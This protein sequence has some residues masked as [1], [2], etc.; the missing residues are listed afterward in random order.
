MGVHTVSLE[1]IPNPDPEAMIWLQNFAS[2]IE[3]KHG[4]LGIPPDDAASLAGLVRDFEQ[5]LAVATSPATRTSPAVTEKTLAR[6]AATKAVRP[7]VKLVRAQPSITDED[8][9]TLGLPLPVER[10]EAV[11]AP[12]TAPI[13]MIRGSV[14]GFHMLNYADSETPFS[15]RKP[16]D[17]MHLQLYLAVGKGLVTLPGDA[18]FH[19]LITRTPFKIQ[20][21]PADNGKTATYFGRWSTRTGLTGPWSLPEGMTISFVQRGT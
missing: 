14:D 5:K 2:K 11:P 9:L 6:N 10:R 21:N 18:A 20:H 15:R 4:S 17:V 3:I 7:I 13:L 1:Y 12:R 8:L 19:S 16:D